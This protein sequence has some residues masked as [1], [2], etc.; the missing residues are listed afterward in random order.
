MQYTTGIGQNILNMWGDSLAFPNIFKSLKQ[1]KIKDY[2]M[3]LGGFTPVFSSFGENV[4]ASDIVQSCIRCIVVE[5]SKLTPKHIRFDYEN[6]MQTTVNSEINRLFRIAPNPLMTT[7]DFLE[8][9]IWLR[10]LTYN[11]FIYP[12]FFMVG[13]RKIYTGLYPLN[14]KMVEFLQDGSETLYIRLTFGNGQNYTLPYNDLIHIRKDYS[15]ND[16]LGGDE[17]GQPHNMSLLK[18]LKTEHT[19]IEGIENGIKAS[20]NIRGIL[21]SQS[22]LNEEKLKEE[23]EKF[24]Q[25][26][27][28]NSSGILSLDIK[29]DYT[30]LPINPKFIDKETL[31]FLES[32]ILNHFGVS[33]PILSGNFTEEQYQAFYEKTLEAVIISLGQAFSKA[34]FTD[35]ELQFGNEI[36]FY[37]QRL[38]FT[39]TKNKI[40][41]ADVLGSRG[42]LTDNQLLEL[43]GYPPYEGGDKRKQSLNYIESEIAKQYQL[44]TKELIKEGES[45]IE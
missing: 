21:K 27:N 39:N 45:K 12:T 4:Y 31:E 38:M 16:I 25:Q 14:P 20:L 34:L 30:N 32:K 13:N 37:P 42:A 29:S 28:N 26:I 24:L 15:L 43:F 5:I 36:I 35:R 40:A 44:D 11:V 22:L 6:N 23:K 10:E 18:I 3:M 1:K 9:I 8:K 17:N 33:L 7:K 41:V 19:V 2:A